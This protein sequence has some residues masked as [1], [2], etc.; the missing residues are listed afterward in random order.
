M[1]CTICEN[2]SNSSFYNRLCLLDAEHAIGAF[3]HDVAKF[4]DRLERVSNQNEY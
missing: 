2:G 3:R 4:I 1:K